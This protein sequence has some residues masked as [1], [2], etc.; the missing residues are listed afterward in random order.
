MPPVTPCASCLRSLAIGVPSP[1][2]EPPTHSPPKR[3]S[4]P[5]PMACRVP[6][7][8]PVEL[9]VQA[10]TVRADRSRWPPACPLNTL[11]V[12]AAAPQNCHVASSAQVGMPEKNTKHAKVKC[13]CTRSVSNHIRGLHWTNTVCLTAGDECII[14][15]EERTRLEI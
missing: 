9:R 11:G 2:P 7:S 12:G 5:P 6:N 3:G 8:G 10:A 14:I 13:Y 15:E 4:P 1:D